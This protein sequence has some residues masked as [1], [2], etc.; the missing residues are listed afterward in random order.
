MQIARSE[1][2]SSLTI[3]NRSAIV[4][5]VSRMSHEMRLASRV[6]ATDTSR[7]QRTARRTR[8]RRPARITSPTGASSASAARPALRCAAL[9][10]CPQ[11]SVDTSREA[12]ALSTCS[13]VKSES[14]S[15][16]FSSRSPLIRS[17]PRGR[18][19]ASL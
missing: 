14:S 10:A 5:N 11:H 19:A 16:A 9:H 8:A 3:I 18:A 13:H 15:I 2:I 6:D 1:A 12:A 4:G 7:P 17:A